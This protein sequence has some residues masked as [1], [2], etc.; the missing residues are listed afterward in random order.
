MEKTKAAES[1]TFRAANVTEALEEVQKTLGPEA[2]IVSVRQV[3]AGMPWQVWRAPQVEVLAIPPV[4]KPEEAAPPASLPALPA[5]ESKD[6]S[7]AAAYALLAPQLKTRLKAAEKPALPAKPNVETQPAVPAFLAGLKNRLIAQGVDEALVQKTTATCAGT[8]HP[9]EMEDE[10]RLRRLLLLQLQALIS[11]RPEAALAKDR[12]VCLAGS[13][14]SGKTSACAKLAAAR[15]QSTGQRVAW[16]CADTI[17][18]GAIAE[19][20]MYTDALGIPLHIAYTSEE[21][22]VAVAAE[23]EAGLIL[24]D[25]PG[26]NPYKESGL[27]QLGDLLTGLAGRTTYLLLPANGKEADLNRSLSALS[28]FHIDGLLVTHLDETGTFGNIFNLAWR[29]RLPLAYFSGGTR[30]PQDLQPAQTGRLAAALMEERWAHYK[31]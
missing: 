4:R 2:L 26:C 28:P 5:G 13:S 16:I 3:P 6:Q 30:V 29:S 10:D 31:D 7:L 11:A 12:V 14:G 21:L 20:R 1:K 9:G 24:V 19:A 15:R 27:I 17:R 22:A 23:S 25:T 18:A 8:L